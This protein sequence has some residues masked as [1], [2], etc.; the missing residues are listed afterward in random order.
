MHGGAVR[1]GT[2]YYPAGRR[3]APGE[4][5]QP[6]AG[7]ANVTRVV[8][9]NGLRYALLADGTVR[10]WLRAEQG[11]ASEIL[12]LEGLTGATQLALGS[13]SSHAP[14]ARCRRRPSRFVRREARRSCCQSTSAT[15]QPSMPPLTRSS[16]RGDTSTSG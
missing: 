8:M 3:A 14:K 7:L 16:H 12:S 6:V 15:R 10:Y 9:A 5:L 2:N 11:Q 1:C 4:G 13:A